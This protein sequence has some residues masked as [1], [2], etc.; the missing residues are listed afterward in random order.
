M[1]PWFTERGRPLPFGPGAPWLFSNDCHGQQPSNVSAG[2]SMA[3]SS[4]LTPAFFSR[5]SLHHGLGTVKPPDYFDYYVAMAG[6]CVILARSLIADTDT[7]L[8]SGRLLMVLHCL[9][10]V[11]CSGYSTSCQWLM[12][13]AASGNSQPDYARQYQAAHGNRPP[14]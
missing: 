2:S 10:P 9:R 14:G 1:V 5:L 6:D 7:E 4:W 8:N 11:I 12:T 13:A 3:Y